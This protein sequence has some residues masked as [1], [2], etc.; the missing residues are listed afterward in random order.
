MFFKSIGICNIAKT[1]VSYAILE[2]ESFNNL[3]CCSY[4]AYEF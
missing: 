3:F 2:L 1:V 4:S